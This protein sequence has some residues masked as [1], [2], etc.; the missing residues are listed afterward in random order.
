M[1]ITKKKKLSVLLHH[2][3]ICY[4]CGELKNYLTVDHIVCMRDGG[5]NSYPN[6]A[7]L[8]VPRHTIK[9]QVEKKV[10][11][12]HTM[13]VCN[14]YGQETSWWKRKIFE[15]YFSE[16]ERKDIIDDI[17]TQWIESDE[18]CTRVETLLKTIHASPQGEVNENS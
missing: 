15:H 14:V 3:F 7:P 11:H 17:T 18:S 9:S 8:C 4:G 6:L 10:R 13:S 16:T 2:R 12:N 5:C 1:P